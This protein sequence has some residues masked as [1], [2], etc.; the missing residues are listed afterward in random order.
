MANIDYYV[1]AGD[2]ISMDNTPG[3][4]TVTTTS[5]STD[6]K[7]NPYT[8]IQINGQPVQIDPY[9]PGQIQQQSP[10]QNPWP[11]PM[12]PLL[13]SEQQAA[14]PNALFTIEQQEAIE[15]MYKRMETAKPAPALEAAEI[16]TVEPRAKR[17]IK[18]PAN[19]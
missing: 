6:F 17:L 13:P 2:S 5:D 12:T 15:K 11:Q 1:Q 4:Y 3:T 8:W 14:Q 19:A 7:Q 18:L 16:A 10:Y 9:Q